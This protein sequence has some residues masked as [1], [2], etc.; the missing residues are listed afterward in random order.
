M[1]FTVDASQWTVPIMAEQSC[2]QFRPN[3]ERRSVTLTT[4]AEG[5]TIPL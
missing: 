3:Y 4:V 2:S 5:R 1:V